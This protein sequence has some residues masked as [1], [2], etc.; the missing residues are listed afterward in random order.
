MIDIHS[1]IL[2]QI[3]DGAESMQDSLEIL[4]AA[5]QSG[6]QTIVATPHFNQMYHWLNYAS[7]ELLSLFNKLRERAD[8]YGLSIDIQLGMEIR[9]FDGMIELLRHKNLLPYA[10]TNYVLV[11]F[12][13]WESE[14]WCT[15]VLNTLSASGYS[16]IIAHPERYE[17]V[18]EKPW[19]VYDWLESGCSI[20]ITK[21]SMLGRFGREAKQTADDFLERGW[22]SFVASDAHG[23]NH[24]T[25]EMKSAYDYLS[26]QYSVKL[27]DLLLYENPQR[28]LQG[29][30][31]EKG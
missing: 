10:D 25:A 27:A 6:V 14:H 7:D 16:P 21:A 17:F 29:K 5:E 12:D 24:R 11:E 30:P 9:A 18:W 1:H 3:D 28:M 20:Q 15:K 4:R 19:M 2:P 26:K 31:L 13:N 23:V 8:K 22:V